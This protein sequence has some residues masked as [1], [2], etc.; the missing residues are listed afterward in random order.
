M[1]EL[2][3][4]DASQN[5]VQI[6][7]DLDFCLILGVKEIIT[8]IPI[9]LYSIEIPYFCLRCHVFVFFSPTYHIYSI[10]SGLIKCNSN[11]VSLL[12]SFQS[13]YAKHK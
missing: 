11:N 6:A 10:Y 7:L 5:D 12:K 9:E 4:L 8:N 3:D 13:V 1:F 2:V